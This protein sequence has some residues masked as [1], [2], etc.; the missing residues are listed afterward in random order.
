MG[1][2]RSRPPKK[3]RVK[4]RGTTFVGELID[5]V[6]E[7]YAEQLPCGFAAT[8]EIF[9]RLKQQSH[10]ALMPHA[11]KLLT[12]LL[13]HLIRTPEEEPRPGVVPMLDMGDHDIY[14]NMLGSDVAT[15]AKAK[16]NYT[17]ELRSVA[18]MLRNLG[19]HM[20]PIDKLDIGDL[21][22]LPGLLKRV[23]VSQWGEEP[24][25]GTLN[26][27]YAELVH[28]LVDFV[29]KQSPPEVQALWVAPVVSLVM[30]QVLVERERIQ[31]LPCR[32]W[33]LDPGRLIAA[34]EAV[35]PALLIHH[36]EDLVELLVFA[37]YGGCITTRLVRLRDL[38]WWTEDGPGGVVASAFKAHNATDDEVAVGTLRAARCLLQCRDPIDTAGDD[39]CDQD[40]RFGSLSLTLM[41][42]LGVKA[43][44]RLAGPRLEETLRLA[45]GV[46]EADDSDEARTQRL[47][48]LLD[49]VGTV[50]RGLAEDNPLCQLAQ[51]FV[52]EVEAPGS[53]AVARRFASLDSSLEA[54]ALDGF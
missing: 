7:A 16:I 24:V 49:E 10:G 18:E 43:L 3:R 11:G 32:S 26:A 51:R 15:V 2:P 29:L 13:P 22:E 44:L 39:A 45:E 19:R 17:K 47:D 40:E 8:E 52:A 35:Q 5:A 53:A 4:A 37:S 50:V 12:T 31:V 9:T 23:A 42:V 20:R 34:L 6:A 33:Q 27:A 48:G 28:E 21:L 1:Q 41:H 25:D 14:F 38:A 54:A 30:T 46:D 36:V